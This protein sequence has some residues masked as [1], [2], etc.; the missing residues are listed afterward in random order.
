MS[1]DELKLLKSSDV[2]RAL[3]MYEGFWMI[4]IGAD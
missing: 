2:W 3:N 4:V 1:S